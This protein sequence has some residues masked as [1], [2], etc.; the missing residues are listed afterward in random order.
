[1]SDIVLKVGFTSQ[2]I[3]LRICQ[4]ITFLVD[5]LNLINYLSFCLYLLDTKFSCSH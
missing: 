1:M 3:I 5:V 2:I 4:K